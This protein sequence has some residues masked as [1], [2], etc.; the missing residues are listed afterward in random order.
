MTLKG[1]WVDSGCVELS[2]TMAF[3]EAVSDTDVPV[4]RYR[5][6]ERAITRVG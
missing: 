1:T 3:M 5:Q 2:V 6:G 4:G